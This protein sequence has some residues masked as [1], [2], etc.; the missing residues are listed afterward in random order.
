MPTTRV[1]SPVWVVGSQ[2]DTALEFSTTLNNGETAVEMNAKELAKARMQK[3][4]EELA[5]IDVVGQSAAGLVKIMFNGKLGS[6]RIEIDQSLMKPDGAAR[7]GELVVSAL[8]DAQSKFDAAA[9]VKM[10]ELSERLS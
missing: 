8:Q 9:Q 3:L 6:R 7:L 1:E 5:L 10:Q 2:S 4:Q